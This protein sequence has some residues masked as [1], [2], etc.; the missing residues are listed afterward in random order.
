[1]A[2]AAGIRPDPK[3]SSIEAGR[4]NIRIRTAEALARAVGAKLRD[5][6]PD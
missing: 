2:Y 5:L 1:M 3:I 4:T 6:L